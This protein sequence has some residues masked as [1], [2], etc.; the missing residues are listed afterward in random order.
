MKK[1][2]THSKRKHMNHSKMSSSIKRCHQCLS[3]K[4][5]MSLF[6]RMLRK[7]VLNVGMFK[8]GGNVHGDNTGVG[9]T[10]D[11]KNTDTLNGA[12][13]NPYNVTKYEY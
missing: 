1:N 4:N 6:G 13:A 11:T 7:G 8:L 5:K 2:T 10:M 9:Y 3:G 12:L